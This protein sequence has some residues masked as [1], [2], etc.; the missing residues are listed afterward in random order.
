MLRPNPAQNELL[1]CLTHVFEGCE[2]LTSE[3]DV[4]KLIWAHWEKITEQA[5]L[6]GFFSSVEKLAPA[7]RNLRLH[8]MFLNQIE[9]RQLSPVVKHAIEKRFLGDERIED[10]ADAYLYDY[11]FGARGNK[12]IFV[13]IHE[14]M[15]IVAWYAKYFSLNFA[16]ILNAALDPAT[17]G[18]D[19]PS[20]GRF[21]TNVLVEMS[22]QL[23]LQKEQAQAHLSSKRQESVPELKQPA[24]TSPSSVQIN[25]TPDGLFKFITA[26]IQ[27]YKGVKKGA[28]EDNQ[29]DFDEIILGAWQEMRAKALSLGII[30]LHQLPPEV[31]NNELHLEFFNRLKMDEGVERVLQHM[32]NEK[33][34]FGGNPLLYAD[35][36]YAD[37]FLEPKK[38]APKIN[39]Y[40]FMLVIVWYVRQYRD[41][42]RDAFNFEDILKNALDTKTR[43]G[44]SFPSHA[45]F[46]VN[47][48]NE[49]W[50]RIH[51]ADC[52]SIYDGEDK[53][54][55]SEEQPPQRVKAV[56]EQSEEQLPP[57]LTKVTD[58]NVLKTIK[59]ELH[60]EAQDK[61]IVYS[62]PSTS[63]YYV[64]STHENCRR[65]IPH[66]Y[67]QNAMQLHDKNRQQ[68]QP[69]LREGRQARLA[70]SSAH[71]PRVRR[72]TA[73]ARPNMQAEATFVQTISDILDNYT[74][75]GL[76]ETHGQHMIDPIIMT[77]WKALRK[78][79][80]AVGVFTESKESRSSLARHQ[81]LH[82][83]LLKE[84]NTEK[85]SSVV[86]E[87][88]K[89]FLNA[90][91]LSRAADVFL[92]DD[93]PGKQ[94]PYYAPINI[95]EFLLICAWY[96]KKHQPPLDFA[97]ILYNALDYRGRGLTK[98]EFPS[99]GGFVVNVLA[100]MWNERRLLLIQNAHHQKSRQP[101]G[102]SPAPV[103]MSGQALDLVED[104][105]LLSAIKQNCDCP[106]EENITVFLDKTTNCYHVYLSLATLLLPVSELKQDNTRGETK[107]HQSDSRSSSAVPLRDSFTP[108]YQPH[109]ST[110]FQPKTEALVNQHPLD[111]KTVRNIL[112]KHYGKMVAVELEAK[113]VIAHHTNGSQEEFT[114]DQL[115]K[116]QDQEAKKTFPSSSPIAAPGSFPLFSAQE[117]F[118]SSSP[119]AAPDP[120]P[121]F[122]A[123]E[124]SS[125]SSPFTAPGPFPLFSAQKSSSSSSPV[126]Q[127]ASPQTV[128]PTSRELQTLD[129]KNEQQ[130]E[131]V[132]YESYAQAIIEILEAEMRDFL[133]RK[134]L[135]QKPE[136]VKT[137]LIKSSLDDFREH[138][139]YKHKD[140]KKNQAKKEEFF[141]DNERYKLL[142]QLKE[143]IKAKKDEAMQRK[144]DKQTYFNT[145]HKEVDQT[146]KNVFLD[147]YKEKRH[148]KH[149]QEGRKT[150]R[151]I[152]NIL[153]ILGGFAFKRPITGTWFYSRK[154]KSKEAVDA[155][156]NKVDEYKKGKVPKL[157]SK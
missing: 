50:N 98:P 36:V 55:Q 65:V 149:H 84:M 92:K 49:I 72:P 18:K 142:F 76:G 116:M 157:G 24:N 13:N 30:S 101:V 59:E 81:E 90:Q 80:I 126:A 28:K 43:R 15:L 71:S 96:A 97:E 16:E 118:S 41:Q 29:H 37:H 143:T 108:S 123:Q 17:T 104:P 6:A 141:F 117:S 3:D 145:L 136:N 120:F 31:R 99:D 7:P 155:A 102:Q 79:A 45:G 115:K 139:R 21:V 40:E 127:G 144:P 38:A 73:E 103:H 4:A 5:K 66:A 130:P 58:D 48:L 22:K 47:V 52:G 12:Y 27:Q 1:R 34:I 121:L 67:V 78:E 8:Q 147:K 44:D 135:V 56:A 2:K 140:P 64:Y 146:A 88:K 111:Q 114:Y 10:A 53:H 63:R 20:N 14:F 75:E 128:Y 70:S 74:G 132:D 9:V 39:I 109:S 87:I 100:Q 94:P 82:A 110:L 93:Y 83:L 119:F 150:R 54:T 91:E 112:L 68:Q 25:T 154:G 57:D 26:V 85:V 51:Y 122:S 138:A 133:I 46:V 105:Q 131:R 106:P 148:E 153:N 107:H 62:S 69:G 42:N 156:L 134:K 152:W 35:D 151:V 124:S 95:H 33:F 11:D 89:R 113:R 86:E 129:W 23:K 61:I 125:S 137:L 60:G 32:K 19:F 77:A